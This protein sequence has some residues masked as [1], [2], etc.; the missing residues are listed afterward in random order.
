MQEPPKETMQ[1]TLEETIEDTLDDNLQKSP[2]EPL[3][4]S[5]EKTPEEFLQECLQKVCEANIKQLLY[6][7]IQLAT[8]STKSG[9]IQLTTVGISYLHLEIENKTWSRFCMYV[10]DVFRECE[11]IML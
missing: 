3:K 1:E 7:N 8:V 10:L 4:K 5:L 9:T 2:Q 6:L 11:L